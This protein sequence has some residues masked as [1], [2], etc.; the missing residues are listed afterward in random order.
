MGTE[1][2]LD[3]EARAIAG[4]LSAALE[5]A[6]N[7]ADGAAFAAPFTA[8]AGFVDIRGVYHQTRDVIAHGH[9]MI[10]QTIYK[11]SK[12]RYETLDARLVAPG[13]LVAHVRGTL[14][15]PSGPLAGVH[16]ALQTIVSL[17]TGGSWQIAAFHNTLVTA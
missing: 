13:C 9:Q 10:F 6:W 14:E 17:L 11:G 5:R 8:D 4:N 2:L 7:T 16:T 12:V 15:A 3:N 1:T